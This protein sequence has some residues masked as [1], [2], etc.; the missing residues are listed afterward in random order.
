MSFS[1]DHEQCI[2][3]EDALSCSFSDIQKRPPWDA[4]VTCLNKG[5]KDTQKNK[6]REAGVASL[7]HFTYTNFCLWYHSDSHDPLC[8]P[9]LGVHS[10][11]CGHHLDTR[12]LVLVVFSLVHF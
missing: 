6:N 4:F 2:P 7:V 12:M 11:S 3:R 10:L 8:L 9:K 1:A 5:L